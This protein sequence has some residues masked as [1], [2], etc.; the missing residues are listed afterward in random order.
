MPKEPPDF[1]CRSAWQVFRLR[2]RDWMWPTAIAVAIA[3][4]IAGRTGG[5]TYK[6]GSITDYANSFGALVLWLAAIF[7]AGFRWCMV[8]ALRSRDRNRC[9]RCGYPTTGL[10]DR[11]PSSLCPECGADA[12][13]RAVPTMRSTLREAFRGV[14]ISRYLIDLPGILVML[15]PVL[16]IVAMLLM[17]FGVID[18]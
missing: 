13:A 18:D 12:T 17:I 5:E 15:Y 11:D 9:A 16:G 1:D 3:I 14:P 8:G 6:I 4:P 2:L 10:D 7:F